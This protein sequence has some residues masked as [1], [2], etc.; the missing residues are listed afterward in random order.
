MDNIL[1]TQGI[2]S[3]CE[4]RVPLDQFRKISQE[5]LMRIS[6]TQEFLQKASIP[7]QGKGDIRPIHCKSALDSLNE[8]NRCIEE[9]KLFFY[10]T[11]HLP[12]VITALRYH[13]LHILHCF[14]IQTSQLEEL[15]DDY[16]TICMTPSK[17]VQ[18]Q[19]IDIYN[20]FETLSQTLTDISQQ[21]KILND[22]ARFQEGRLLAFSE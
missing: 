20:A 1:Q 18:K 13:T 12:L 14:E 16:R 9:F 15:L 19:R 6:H 7:F 8:M 2:N 10:T 17:R 4:T 21:V 11:S 3:R 5:H 22:E